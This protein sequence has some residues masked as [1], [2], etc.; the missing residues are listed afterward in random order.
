MWAKEGVVSVVEM[1]NDFF[2][3]TFSSRSDYNR[4]LIGGPWMIQDHYLTVKKWKRSFD[5]TS[6]ATEEAIV[7]V[8]LTD[9]PL[10]AYE[11]MIFTVTGD[12]IRKTMKVDLSTSLLV[13]GSYARLGVQVNL[14]E[15][16][17]PKIIYEGKEYAVEYGGLHLLFFYYG[18]YGYL[19][20][21]CQ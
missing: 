18:R 5:P 20:R 4:A 1:T 12:R 17:L 7:W 10:E 16:L 6:E 8:R 21:A 19:E 13:R 14:K 9:F 11:E 3:V 15:S 2:V